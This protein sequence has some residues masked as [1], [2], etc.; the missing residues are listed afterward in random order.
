MGGNRKL[1]EGPSEVTMIVVMGVDSKG[2]LSSKMFL[3]LHLAPSKENINEASKEGGTLV[4][5]PA[6][7][8]VDEEVAMSSMLAAI[9]GAGI[10]LGKF[11][12]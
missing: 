9:G 7:G 8:S 10:A 3:V 2:G 1:G 4:E 6:S 12:G 5:G 11:Q